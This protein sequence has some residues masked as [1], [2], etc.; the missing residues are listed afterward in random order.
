MVKKFVALMLAT[1]AL[2]ILPLVRF[3]FNSHSR[4]PQS[5]PVIAWIDTA[6][7]LP[8]ALAQRFD[9]D[10]V[11][12]QVYEQL[13]NLPLE[14]QYITQETGEVAQ[15]NTL[16]GRFIRYHIYVKG[17]PPI[18]RLDWKLSLADYLGVNEFISAATY[19][20]ADTLMTNPFEGDVAAVQNLTRSERDALVQVL[21]NIFSSAFA[22]SDSPAPNSNPTPDSSPSPLTHSAPAPRP[23]SPQP[24]AAD[25]LLP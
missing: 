15:D 9:L 5:Y 6:T 16:V 18:Y 19:P 14:N 4:S 10:A 1:I 25:L 11:W 24:G 17:R 21:V 7:S 22:N 2:I 13:P 8:P 12:R 3:P 20:S 23:V